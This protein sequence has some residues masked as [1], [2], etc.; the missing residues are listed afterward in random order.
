MCEIVLCR[1][2]PGFAAMAATFICYHYFVVVRPCDTPA[3]DSY[4]YHV[5]S[6]DDDAAV[7]RSVP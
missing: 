1:E 6:C 4:Q 2:F 7:W 3:L 5:I